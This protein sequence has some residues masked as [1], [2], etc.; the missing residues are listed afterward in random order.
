SKVDKRLQY[1][2]NMIRERRAM[3][4]RLCRA[5]Q[6]EPDELL[7]TMKNW[8]QHT[9]KQILDR[10]EKPDHAATNR[11]IEL[12]GIP[13]RT[14]KEM[15][16]EESSGKKKWL[17]SQ[18]LND[19]ITKE[20]KSI[21]DVLEFCP[22]IDEL[23]VIG[24]NRWRSLQCELE[25]LRSIST[26]NSDKTQ[27]IPE[28]T[29]AN[30]MC[31][32]SEMQLL[33][34]LAVVINGTNYQRNRP[35]YSPMLE[36]MFVCNPFEYCL[37]VIMRIE[38]Y[39]QQT[40]IFKWSRSDFFTSNFTLFNKD[41][42][43]FVF[44]NEP[45]QLATGEVR[46]VSVLFRPLKVGIFKQRWM[47][48]TK[49]RIFLSCPCALTLNMHGRCTP[50]QAYLELIESNM[51]NIT[52]LFDQ[53]PNQIQS[54][55]DLDSEDSGQPLLPYT[56]ELDTSEAFNQ[57]NVGFHCLSEDAVDEVNNFFELVKPE[58]S[59]LQW[60]YSVG[61][62][63]DLMCVQDEKSRRAELFEDLQRLLAKLRGRSDEHRLSCFE[64]P[65]R[66]IQRH[67]TRFIYVR[68]VVCNSFDVWEQ[69][70]CV[71]T[72]KM[73]RAKGNPNRNTNYSK[74][75]RDSLYIYTYHHLCDVVE[76]IVSVI[77][78]TEQV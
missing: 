23:E 14:Y 70:I 17:G 49:P 15:L 78:S 51:N 65:Q 50:P 58:D 48:T 9:I 28:F 61:M 19:K 66:I 37:K 60:D 46:E 4:N 71:L 18:L 5:T 36:R 55:A 62:L 77:E 59:P 27:R 2:K 34:R 8:E 76:D 54:S 72:S 7:F 75:Y 68:G 43:V 22:D 67:R 47:L 63:I 56:R 12:V 3:Q 69:K 26:L 30:S 21:E 45:F 31:F 40:L 6:K 64:H 39:G 11:D 73:L 41:E 20:F 24:V 10:A 57:R 32:P 74:S 33:P 13:R 35:E 53:V 52:M 38:N 29:L 16:G 42:D 44:D 25:S 1:W